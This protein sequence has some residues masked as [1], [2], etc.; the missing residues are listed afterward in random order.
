MGKT[1]TLCLER[2]KERSESV[3]SASLGL[4]VE[5]RLCREPLQSIKS[6]GGDA[7]VLDLRVWMGLIPTA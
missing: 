7:W 6:I 2:D 1:E 3:S 4:Q 5:F